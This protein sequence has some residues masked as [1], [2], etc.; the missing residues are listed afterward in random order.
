[1]RSS[2]TIPHATVCPSIYSAKLKT[3][4]LRCERPVM[5]NSDERF[6][7]MTK[8]FLVVQ[9]TTCWQSLSVSNKPR[10]QL[11]K[12]KRNFWNTIFSSL[13]FFI[14]IYFCDYHRQPLL[15]AMTVHRACDPKYAILDLKVF[16][17][18]WSLIK[19]E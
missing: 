8:R 15:Q 16:I 18:Y 7:G 3:I 6:D 19:I 5:E 9:M 13:P 14:W 17:I 2:S 12:S 1:M 10:I 11:P 4:L